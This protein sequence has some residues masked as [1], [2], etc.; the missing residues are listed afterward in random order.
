MP[1]NRI[2]GAELQPLNPELAAF[3]DG[4]ERGLLVLQVLSAT[5]ASELGLRPGDVIVE[6]AGRPVASLA[7]FRRA[8]MEQAAPEVRWVRRGRPM[9]DTL[10]H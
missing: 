6:A 4:V 10:R 8:L 2:A 5:P 9:A 3:F 1:G 7:G